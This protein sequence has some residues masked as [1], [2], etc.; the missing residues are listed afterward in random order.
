M[1]KPAAATKALRAVLLVADDLVAAAEKARR[2]LTE[3]MR[4]PAMRKAVEEIML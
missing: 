3:A 1:D 4:R 2:V